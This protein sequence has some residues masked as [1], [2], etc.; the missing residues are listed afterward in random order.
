MRWLNLNTIIEMLNRLISP[1]S[2]SDE[3]LTYSMIDFLW[4]TKSVEDWQ[5][6]PL[7]VV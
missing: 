5:F 6:L 1:E 2:V 7:I 3:L 4:P